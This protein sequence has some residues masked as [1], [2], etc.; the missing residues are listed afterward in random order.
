MKEINKDEKIKVTLDYEEYIFLNEIIN[1]I[2]P[3][4]VTSF[5]HTF[6]KK[7]DI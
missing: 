3:D 4:E 6:F 5:H 1:K 2:N 7:R